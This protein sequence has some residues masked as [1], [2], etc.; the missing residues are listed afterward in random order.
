M[1]ITV[2]RTVSVA[3]SRELCPEP[4]PP[5]TPP[6]LPQAASNQ[7]N[8]VPNVDSMESPAAVAAPSEDALPYA[9]FTRRH[10]KKFR[11]QAKQLFLTYPQNNTPKE[12]A[13]ERL[14]TSNKNLDIKGVLI[15]QEQH[16]TGW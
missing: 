3:A 7:R 1:I 6:V 2:D 15:A 13:L 16:K 5:C 9:S 14:L 12:V 8:I 11:L 10:S 4:V